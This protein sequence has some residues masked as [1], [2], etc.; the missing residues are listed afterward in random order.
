[1][2]AGW[3]QRD[4]PGV[5]AALW[6]KGDIIDRFSVVCGL[7]F[8]AAGVWLLLGLTWPLVPVL[9]ILMGVILLWN[10]LFAAAPR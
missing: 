9:L 3:R 7:M 2:V 1:M 10:V 4:H 5:Q 6:L 8:L